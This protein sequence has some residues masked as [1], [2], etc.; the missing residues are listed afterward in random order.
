MEIFIKC[1]MVAVFKEYKYPPE[2]HAKLAVI[3]QAWKRIMTMDDSEHVLIL[4]RIADGVGHVE[5]CDLDTR[6]YNT[7]DGRVTIYN[8]QRD[9][10]PIQ[11]EFF[12]LVRNDRGLI[13]YVVD[14]DKLKQ[15]FTENESILHHTYQPGQTFSNVPPQVQE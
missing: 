4:G 10:C 11:Q 5:V 6:T 9:E 7:V 1:E 13:L 2:E 3:K 14:L 12:D 8:P 15:K